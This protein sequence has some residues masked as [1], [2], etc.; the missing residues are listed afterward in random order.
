[1]FRPRKLVAYC[2]RRVSMNPVLS[3]LTMCVCAAG[4]GAAIIPAAHVVKRHFR[5]A[6]HHV[7]R[8]PLVDVAA[9][10]PDCL[11]GVTL[12]GGGLGNGAG[13]GGGGIGSS[14]L[15]DLAPGARSGESGGGF[16]FGGF[17]SCALRWW[18]RLPGRWWRRRI[19]WW[20]WPS[21]W[22]RWRDP[23][24]WRRD[25]SR[26]RRWRDPAG[27]ALDEQRARAGCMGADGRGASAW[28][29]AR[30]ATTVSVAGRAPLEA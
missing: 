1:M 10:R 26:R 14:G 29:V 2:V 17:Q 11:P 8:G 30:S 22:R 18:R 19:G 6:V 16:P 27:T 7:A 4:T 3:K 25:P 9:A 20:R 13:G 12:A 23:A 21:G 24:G 5:P 28:R 15:T